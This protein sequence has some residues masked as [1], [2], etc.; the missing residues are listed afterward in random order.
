MPA[1]APQRNAEPLADEWSAPLVS[2]LIPAYNAGRT[3]EATLRSALSQTWAR[4]EII[5]VDDGST[6]DTLAVARRVAPGRIQVVS[7]TN[8]GAA[9][10]RNTAFA[11]SR[12][13]YIQWLDADDLLAPDK[14]G[15]QLRA[16]PSDCT[17]RTLLCCGWAH[18]LHRPGAARFVASPLWDD[19]MPAEWMI[20]KM[21]H[22]AHMQ[23][24]TWLT[25]R[26][27]CL[28]AG[29]WDP[30]L[31]VDDDGEYFCRVLCASD[32]VAFTREARTY[33]RITGTGSLSYVG[34]GG[35]KLDAQLL[36][37]RMHVDTLLALERSERSIAACLV[38]LQKY[39]SVFYGRRPDLVA[40]LQTMANGLGGT[41][42]RPRLSW[43]YAWIDRLFGWQAA[44]LCS[45]RYNAAKWQLARTLDRGL[46]AL[47][48][49]GAT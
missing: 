15:L 16:R 29:P 27:L 21:R 39:M 38:Y 41:L 1:A 23:P 44:A 28:A 42:T 49:F 11:L 3:I 14:I 35:A 33:Y 32:R 40:Q 5:V 34:S 17:P 18:F 12:G 19:L 45:R 9:A 20:R 47:S 43:K 36:S 22:D 13:G 37:C 30:R 48:R 2:I 6:D 4:T 31:L 24:A 26:E 8:R 25:T 7:Q 10:A 46:A